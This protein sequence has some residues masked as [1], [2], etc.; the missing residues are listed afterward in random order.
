M[1]DKTCRLILMIRMLSVGKE[2]LVAKETAV[3]RET[4][5]DK[6]SPANDKSSVATAVS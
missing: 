2:T 3:E 5:V 6:Y 4:S 1:M